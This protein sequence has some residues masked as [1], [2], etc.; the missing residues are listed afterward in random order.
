MIKTKWYITINGKLY[1]KSGKCYHKFKATLEDA[2]LIARD[3]A[4]GYFGKGTFPNMV[5]IWDEESNCY[6]VSK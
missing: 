1:G 6:E 4:T 5:K 2:I 3:C